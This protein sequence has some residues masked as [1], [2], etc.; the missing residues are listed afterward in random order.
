MKTIWKYPLTPPETGDTVEIEMPEGAW[1]LD[2]QLNGREPALWAMV[3]S[4]RPKKKRTFRFFATGSD[5]GPKQDLSY[6]GTFQLSTL[7][8]G[9]L[10]FH[11]FEVVE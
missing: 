8:H 9:I 5:M 2:V 6:V 7:I 10:V 11:L 3:D 1:V 4:E